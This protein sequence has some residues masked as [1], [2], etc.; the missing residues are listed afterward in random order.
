MSS[1]EKSECALTSRIKRIQSLLCQLLSQHSKK[2]DHPIFL[3]YFLENLTSTELYPTLCN[4]PAERHVLAYSGGRPMEPIQLVRTDG[5][6]YKSVSCLSVYQHP[7]DTTRQ[8]WINV[9]NLI[10]K[11][12]K[13]DKWLLLKITNRDE[14][15]PS[16]ISEITYFLEHCWME[17]FWSQGSHRL[18]VR[19]LL[20]FELAQ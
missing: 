17:P 16:F 12:V 7:L 9:K 13:Y 3:R 4:Q 18:H 2:L 15:P 8:M 10:S 19:T 5:G 11:H 1:W 20:V 6:P 14:R